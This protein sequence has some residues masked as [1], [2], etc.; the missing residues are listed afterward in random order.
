MHSE[1]NDAWAR[2]AAK[3]DEKW[4]KKHNAYVVNGILNHDNYL[5]ELAIEHEIAA[6]KLRAAPLAK[7]KSE[8]AKREA[9][10]QA[11]CEQHENFLMGVEDVN[12][13]KALWHWQ[14]DHQDQEDI[15]S[16]HRLQWARRRN[17][18]PRI[19]ARNL[20]DPDVR[21]AIQQMKQ[22]P[23]DL[24]V[25]TCAFRLL[26][27]RTAASE[28]AALR[29]LEYGAVKVVCDGLQFSLTCGRG[30]F[31]DDK[32]K[33]DINDQITSSS[34][35][36]VGSRLANLDVQDDVNPSMLTSRNG[37]TETAVLQA[38]RPAVSVLARL[39]RVDEIARYQLS[40]LG[41]FDAALHG[42]TRFPQDRDLQRNLC[43]LLTGLCS[44]DIARTLAS[45]GG[46][47]MQ[48]IMSNIRKEMGWPRD[49]IK[50]N[51]KEISKRAKIKREARSAGVKMERSTWE[52]TEE[53]SGKERFAR[54]R[55]LH[56]RAADS[57]L[58]IAALDAVMALCA[59]HDD[60]KRDACSCG[61][62]PI[63][64]G[65]LSHYGNPTILNETRYEGAQI[66]SR[67]LKCIWGLCFD[68]NPDFDDNVVYRI[69]SEL[70]A[71][72]AITMMSTA[73]QTHIEDAPVQMAMF[74][75][76]Y[77]MLSGLGA[78]KKGKSACD[79]GLSDKD[80]KTEMSTLPSPQLLESM[81]SAV[82][83]HHH[84][85]SIVW[86]CCV[87][88]TLMAQVNSMVPDWWSRANG[89]QVFAGS[90]ETHLYILPVQEQLLQCFWTVCQ[91]PSGGQRAARL[92][93]TIIPAQLEKC[94][95]A[96]REDRNVM[97][98]VNATKGAISR[99]YE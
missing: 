76:A 19:Q 20:R 85:T 49:E 22:S 33:D 32:L 25:Q 80:G 40:A 77:A 42:A 63:L 2:A 87:N 89:P 27:M 58:I 98:W 59:K 91:G 86:Q 23:E 4:D 1:A 3:A 94:Q 66:V 41:A 54:L 56:N 6:K 51:S 18:V 16:K 14:Y 11:I 88:V 35:D 31:T 44:D 10:I 72:Q 47:T 62:L 73:A 55:A 15:V 39:S 92:R 67:C 48:L 28:E 46:K 97:H 57:R 21:A 96:H 61:I 36:L 52:K 8:K 70:L 38:V 78:V 79:I 69:S 29:A 93:S 53:W 12:A 50:K 65:L 34:N 24:S 84:I 30:D 26:Q 74:Q 95:Y 83:A 13:A 5:G 64:M 81:V 37:E 60:N 68:P 90:F 9:A 43:D 82:S 71:A 17:I 75:A 7:R 45:Q 99:E